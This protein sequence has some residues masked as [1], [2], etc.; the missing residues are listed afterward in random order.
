MKALEDA[1]IRPSENVNKP[2][3]AIHCKNMHVY[4]CVHYVCMYVDTYVHVHVLSFVLSYQCCVHILFTCLML[5]THAIHL[6]NTLFLT[7]HI[8]LH[9]PCSM[10][11]FFITHVHVSFA[12]LYYE[13]H[14]L[15][16]HTPHLYVQHML[17][18]C[19]VP[20]N[21]L[22]Y[23]HCCKNGSLVQAF[24]VYMYMEQPR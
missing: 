24:H 10:P 23:G 13:V 15:S 20:C 18:V 1:N 21:L 14:A 17:C 8:C 2:V 4:M 19:D 6:T 3:E 12:C 11:V 5:L 7:R 9:S 16:L 22:L